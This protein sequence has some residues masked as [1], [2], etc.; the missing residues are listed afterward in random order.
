MRS[1]TIGASVLATTALFG[2][3]TGCLP[4]GGGKAADI[5]RAARAAEQA[6]GGAT[7]SPT[8]KG[9]DKSTGVLAD[10]SGAEILS[11]SYEA[12]R[13]VESAHVVAKMHDDARQVEF[14]LSLDRKNDCNGA[15]R[16][17]GMGKVDLIKSTDLMHFKGDADYWRAVAAKKHTPK[18]QT[19][20]MVT[21]LA[22][23]WLKMPLSDPEATS[24][25]HVCDLGKLT[26]G[27]SKPSPL[28]RKGET[29][30][31]D[32]KQALTITSAAKE[33]TEIDYIAAQGTPYL[34]KSTISGDASGEILFSAF[35]APVDTALPEG[36]DV[37]DLSKLRG[38]AP[39]ESV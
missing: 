20:A 3:T 7:P 39:G 14:D 12:M 19:D 23:R 32:G 38:G 5:G 37:L 27:A 9:K 30:A 25:A 26:G 35:G 4:G 15:I 17:E 2:L 33:G 10:L 8:A 28:A 18:K 11:Q 21:M 6:P 36:A 16:Y 24:I 13:K 29:V 22:D 31:I 1:R 34:L